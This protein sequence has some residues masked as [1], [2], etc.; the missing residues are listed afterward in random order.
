VLSYVSDII[1][2]NSESLKKVK[3]KDP[4]IILELKDGDGKIP[5]RVSIDNKGKKELSI[6]DDLINLNG[7]Y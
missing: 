7:E 6:S 3:V 5:A 2:S 4:T 1:W